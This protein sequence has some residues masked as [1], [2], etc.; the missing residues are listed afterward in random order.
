[1]I[2]EEQKDQIKHALLGSCKASYKVASELDLDE[3][4]VEDIIPELEIECCSN[5]GWWSESSEFEEIEAD[6][7]CGDCINDL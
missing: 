2:T 3:A 1:M 7:V 5:C 6:L 4:E